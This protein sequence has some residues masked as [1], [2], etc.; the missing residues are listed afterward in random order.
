MKKQDRTEQLFTDMKSVFMPRKNLSALGE[1]GK[2]RIVEYK[3]MK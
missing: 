3:A 1:K 2:W